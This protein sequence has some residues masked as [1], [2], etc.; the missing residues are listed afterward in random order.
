[1][2]SKKRHSESKLEIS[3]KKT[4]LE[5]T[6]LPYIPIEIWDIIISFLDPVY[7]GIYRFVCKEWK[8]Y[9][10]CDHFLIK[11]AIK[12]LIILGDFENTIFLIK[13]GCK[14]RLNYSEDQLLILKKNNITNSN[15]LFNFIKKNFNR[16]IV[17]DYYHLSKIAATINHFEMLKWL[18]EEKQ[19]KLDNDTS[20]IAANNGNFEIIKYAFFYGSPMCNT[21]YYAALNG[22]LDILIW[23][24]QNGQI[25]NKKGILS[26]AS[27]NNH[28][29]I[30]IWAHQNGCLWEQNATDHAAFCGHLNLLKWIKQNIYRWKHKQLTSNAAYGGQFKI[31]KWLIKNKCVYNELT[32]SSAAQNGHLKILKWLRKN[33][34][35]WNENT[36]A[37][38]A[39]NGHLKVLKWAR[40]NNCP[41][42]ENTCTLAAQF[43]HLKIIK[44]AKKNNCPWDYMTCVYAVNGNHFAILKWALKNNCHWHDD[45]FYGAIQ[46]G[47]LEILIWLKENNYLQNSN[48]YQI[49]YFG[50]GR[51]RYQTY[52][53]LF[54]NGYLW[55][56]DIILLFISHVRNKKKFIKWTLGNNIEWN[57][58]LFRILV[59]DNKINFIKIIKQFHLQLIDAT[60]IAIFAARYGNFKIL[61]L[62]KDYINQAVC[63]TAVYY[64]DFKIVEWLYQNSYPFTSNAIINALIGKNKIVYIW[65]KRKMNFDDNQ[66]Y[67][68]YLTEGKLSILELFRNDQCFCIKHEPH[69]NNCTSQ[70]LENYREL[71]PWLNENGCIK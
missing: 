53:W 16:I 31:L 68:K 66:I 55:N 49:D 26:G 30:I 22:H 51:A 8:N 63:N 1:M 54:Q 71:L 58:A 29:N 21:Y 7:K 14:I 50:L 43:G 64:G 47:R 13:Y 18:I 35:P 17:K 37:A 2:I 52:I 25:I 44:W 69:Q 24:H 34:C 33:N 39:S 42:D 56:T 61:K 9:L 19:C 27:I 28:L 4:K 5:P 41:W 6:N 45:I 38:A 36:C 3:P 12:Q 32:C 57:N 60:K 65:L 40:K 46:N 10:Q 23:L 20:S 59:R 70:Y 15:C 48:K 11:N 62:F 67:Q